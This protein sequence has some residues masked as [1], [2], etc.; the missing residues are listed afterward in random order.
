MGMVGA[1]RSRLA[2]SHRRFSEFVLQDLGDAGQ[3]SSSPEVAPDEAST[4]TS[5][6][7]QAEYHAII[8]LY[9]R[10]GE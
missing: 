4:T 9:L 5:G 7:K 8:P 2:P 10:D 3:Q 1:R 6:F